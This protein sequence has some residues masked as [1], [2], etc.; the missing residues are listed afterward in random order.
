MAIAT[1][2]MVKSAFF[3]ESSIAGEV[4]DCLS[5]NG[6]VKIRVLDLISDAAKYIFGKSF[7]DENMVD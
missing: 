6:K 4:I 7:K 2:V 5:G 3:E 1:E